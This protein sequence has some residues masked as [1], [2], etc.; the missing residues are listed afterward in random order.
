MQEINQFVVTDIYFQRGR[1]V[2]GAKYI[3]AT[4]FCSCVP[5]SFHCHI[6]KTPTRVSTGM[7]LVYV[8]TPNSKNN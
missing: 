5:L 6:Y 7:E 4:F 8:V 1:V 2:W 3:F